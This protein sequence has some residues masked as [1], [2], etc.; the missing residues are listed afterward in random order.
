MGDLT[1]SGVAHLAPNTTT[2]RE[3]KP[4]LSDARTLE[5]ER[6]EKTPRQTSTIRA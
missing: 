5:V 4:S 2:I 3:I 6:D 1:C